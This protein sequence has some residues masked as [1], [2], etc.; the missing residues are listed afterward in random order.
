MCTP[1]LKLE[2]RGS[3]HYARRL[4]KMLRRSAAT[5]TLHIEALRTDPQR[6]LE[7]LLAR[8]A[9]YSDCVSVWIDERVRPVVPIDSS[10]FHLLLARDRHTD[11][12]PA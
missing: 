3:R 12:P 11:P 7:R 10:I 8:L 9:P 4:E 1:L 6:Q 2:L 5:V